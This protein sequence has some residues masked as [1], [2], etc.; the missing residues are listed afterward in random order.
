MDFLDPVKKRAHERR[1]FIGYFLIGIAIIM[2]SAILVIVSNGYDYDRK[3]GQVIHNGIIF[4]ATTPESADIY[5][6]GQA[7]G[8]TD[9]RLTVPAGTYD[10][11]FRR[12]GYDSWKKK[13]DLAGGS[14]EQL[15]YPRL[16][17]TKLVTAETKRYD[18][19]P[20][21]SSQSPDRRW[22]MISQPGKAASFEVFDTAN[23]D[24]APTIINLKDSQITPVRTGDKEKLTLVEWSTDNRHVLIKHVF[25]KS[26]EF[27][28][29]DRQDA[30]SSY[31]VNT[32]FKVSPSE[33][34]LR[35]KK[36]DKLYFYFAKTDILQASELKDKK[37]VDI[38]TKVTS[39][40]PYRDKVILF[41]SD[42]PKTPELT[43]VKMLDGDKIHTLRSFKAGPVLLDL[44][45]YNNDLYVAA[46]PVVEDR[47]VIFKDPIGQLKRTN[48]KEAGALALMRITDPTKLSF[49]TNARFI[50][51]ESGAKFA[52]YDLEE[53]ERYS[54]TVPGQVP[55]DQFA[56]WMDGHRMALNQDSRVVVFEFDGANHRDLG[57]IKIGTLPFFDQKYERLNTLTP[58]AGSKAV[59]LT[60]TSLKVKLEP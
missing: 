3:T 11:E 7:N 8:Q 35:D 57:A 49:S 56:T 34:R 22:I 1:L 48:D 31:N 45:S 27:V 58:V 28:V 43:T 32:T 33:V 2:T 38:L 44:A 50:A 39:F 16:F 40:K 30:T 17:P 52:T 51:V 24:Q 9:K 4:T 54:F 26:S 41:T 5:L 10:I 15:V 13:L 55:A 6:N 47:I 59:S 29:I 37:I 25:G 23:R 20:A 46:V 14:V 18:S 53:Q 21:F 12:Q 60:R 36:Y 19:G 42:D